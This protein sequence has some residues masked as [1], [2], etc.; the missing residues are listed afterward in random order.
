M[1]KIKLT[2]T[3]LTKIISKVLKEKFESK[4]QARFFHAKANEPG[5]RRKEMEKMDQGIF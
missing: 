5:K 3:Q 1:K 4:A 2:E